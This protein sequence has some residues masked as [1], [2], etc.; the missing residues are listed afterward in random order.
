M[1]ENKYED[2]WRLGE[3]LLKNLS[4]K[5]L[6]KCLR[7]CGSFDFYNAVRDEC[8]IRRA[9]AEPQTKECFSLSNLQPLS[10]EANMKKG[11]K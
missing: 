1:N 10:K 11:M 5:E 4:N 2:E 9:K 7:P 6:K 3:I 8:S